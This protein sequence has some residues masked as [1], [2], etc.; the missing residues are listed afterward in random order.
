MIIDPGCAYTRVD[1]L[2]H[3]KILFYGEV[4]QRIPRKLAA[5]SSSKSR[6]AEWM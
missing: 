5:P 1:E 6:S 2:I 3:T 4:A